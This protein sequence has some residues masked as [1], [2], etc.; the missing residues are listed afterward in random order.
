MVNCRAVPPRGV[1]IG[2]NHACGSDR[3]EVQKASIDQ[4]HPPV[5]T[6][7]SGLST[8]D[9]RRS[10]REIYNIHLCIG[11]GRMILFQFFIS[12]M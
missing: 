7:V 2:S 9:A 3:L 4:V 10:N 8:F 5:M 1:R 6:V 12:L 11:R